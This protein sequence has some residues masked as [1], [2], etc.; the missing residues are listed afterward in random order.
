MFILFAF[1]AK[2]S[3][4]TSSHGIKNSRIVLFFTIQSGY[5]IETLNAIPIKIQTFTSTKF[6]HTILGICVTSETQL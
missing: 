2:E 1:G 4:P 3:P 6:L 5:L